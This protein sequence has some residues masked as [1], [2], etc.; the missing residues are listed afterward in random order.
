MKETEAKRKC[1]VLLAEDNRINQK[2]VV[3]ML[4]KMGINPDIAMDGL[5]AVE[6]ALQK[7]YDLILMDMHMP[8]MS[9]LDATR[10]IKSTL[11]ETS[12]VIVA[13]TAD[14]TQENINDALTGGV[15][16]YLTKPVSMDMLRD[17]VEKH[18]R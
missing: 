4:G 8:A 13:L 7:R 3:L 1:T 16:A 15:D 6:M 17:C 11:G 2:L 5:Q 9:G 10:K 14:V 18:V 12:P